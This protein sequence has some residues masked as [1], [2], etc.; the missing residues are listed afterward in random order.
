MLG[1]FVTVWGFSGV[2]SEFGSER[3]LFLFGVAVNSTLWAL[4][5]VII[6]R[7]AYSAFVQGKVTLL[8]EHIERYQQFLASLEERSGEDRRRPE[9]GPLPRV[10]GR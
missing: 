6:F 4:L 10:A 9:E 8:A 1:I 5:Y 3:L 2:A 7:I